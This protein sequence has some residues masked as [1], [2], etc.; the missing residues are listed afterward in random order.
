MDPSVVA[1][2]A[3][4]D[5]SAQVALYQFRIAFAN[6]V[7]KSSVPYIAA[8]G[9]FLADWS[10]A[11]FTEVEMLLAPFRT[12]TFIYFTVRIS[13]LSAFTLYLL[14][15]FAGDHPA[16]NCA[17]VFKTIAAFALISAS[18]SYSILALR[19]QALLMGRKVPTMMVW[20]AC[21]LTSL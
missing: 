4:G 10:Y 1:A 11:I 8:F 15:L 19:A 17:A 12:I 20:A 16:V 9:F 7:I 21:T 3:A 5:P 2:A 18:A 14:Q 6:A 13:T